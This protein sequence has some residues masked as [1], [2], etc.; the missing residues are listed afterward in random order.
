M[1]VEQG[2]EWAAGEVVFTAGDRLRMFKPCGRVHTVTIEQRNLEAL[3]VKD[4][5]MWPEEERRIGPILEAPDGTDPLEL[6]RATSA[7][8]EQRR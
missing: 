6:M 2:G 5:G 7:A 8:R 4:L 3:T 1:D